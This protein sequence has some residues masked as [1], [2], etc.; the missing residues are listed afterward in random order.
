MKTTQHTAAMRKKRT[1]ADG[2]AKGSNRLQADPFSAE[3]NGA[4]AQIPLKNSNFR[5]DHNSEDRWQLRWRI[6]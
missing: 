3:T 4:N 2:D 5:V 1:I 6:P